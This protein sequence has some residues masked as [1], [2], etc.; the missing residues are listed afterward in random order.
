MQFAEGFIN[1]LDIDPDGVGECHHDLDLTIDNLN[2][3]L[4]DLIQISE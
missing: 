4:D 2:I 3:I 1:G